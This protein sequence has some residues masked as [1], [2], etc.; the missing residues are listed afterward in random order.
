M[1]FGEQY[2]SLQVLRTVDEKRKGYACLDGLVKD[3]Q[4]KSGS[5]QVAD[6]AKVARAIRAFMSRT[7]LGVMDTD[8]VI[9]KVYP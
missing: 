8:E 9:E 7:K 4:V 6:V 2:K 3:L 5:M 1:D